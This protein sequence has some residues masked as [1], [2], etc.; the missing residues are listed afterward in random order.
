MKLEVKRHPI[1]AMALIWRLGMPTGQM[2]GKKI[3]ICQSL[4]NL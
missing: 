4:H 2:Y 3:C 1:T